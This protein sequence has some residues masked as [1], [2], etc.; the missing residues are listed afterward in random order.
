MAMKISDECSACGV[1]E[2][3]CP[4]DAISEGDE[5]YVIDAEKCTE[6]KGEADAPQCAEVCPVECISKV[7]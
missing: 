1:C 6:C 5:F 4:S 7:E 3:E 2:D